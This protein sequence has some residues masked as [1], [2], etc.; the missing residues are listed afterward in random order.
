MN[1]YAFPGIRHNKSTLID[2]APEFIRAVERHFGLPDGY[3]R[4]PAPSRKP[5]LYK[6]INVYSIRQSIVYLLLQS[7]P[8]PT[9]KMLC[10]IVGMQ[11]H[12]SVLHARDAAKTYLD[13]ED[14]LFRA[15]FDQVCHIADE[16]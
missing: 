10:P 5:P 11:H 6:G 1:A 13:T 2:R 9:L 12:T 15:I 14:P 16:M 3:F 8:R 7:K 4:Q